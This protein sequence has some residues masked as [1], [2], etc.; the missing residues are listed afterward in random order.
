MKNIKDQVAIIITTFVVMFGAGCLSAEDAPRQVMDEKVPSL[1]AL[2]DI[3][4][5]DFL[6]LG[7][8][9]DQDSSADSRALCLTLMTNVV[10]SVVQTKHLVKEDIEAGISMIKSL[11]ESRMV[12]TDQ[13]AVLYLLH[14][15]S[16]IRPV[17]TNEYALELKVADDADVELQKERRKRPGS[18][19]VVGRYRGPRVRALEEKWEPIFEHN[20]ICAEFRRRAVEVFSSAFPDISKGKDGDVAEALFSAVIRMDGF[21]P[22]EKTAILGCRQGQALLMQKH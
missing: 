11:L 8:M 6:R 17:S 9:D 3:C 2:R 13:D 20:R 15:V 16:C 7:A 22:D 4:H 1:S 5:S 10:R 18:L 19:S 21:A 14:A 12:T